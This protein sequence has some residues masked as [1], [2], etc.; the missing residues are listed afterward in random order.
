M[1]GD[2]WF[3]WFWTGSQGRPPFQPGRAGLWRASRHPHGHPGGRPSCAPRPASTLGACPSGCALMGNEQLH[4]RMGD[5]VGVSWPPAAAGCRRGPS[6]LSEG[7]RAARPLSPGQRA[8]GRVVHRRRRAAA[9]LPAPARGAG[10]GPL[11]RRRG[12]GERTPSPSPTASTAATRG[13]N[14]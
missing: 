13:S 10:A 1:A 4:A 14:R 11:G 3:Y 7:L 2:A 6:D 8:R 12:G 9:R 5:S